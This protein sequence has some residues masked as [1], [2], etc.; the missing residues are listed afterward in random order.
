MAE[1]FREFFLEL[2]LL[3]KK[4]IPVCR[5]R[6]SKSY[7]LNFTSRPAR[8][9][10]NKLYQKLGFKRKETNVYTMKFT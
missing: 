2:A 10:A 1:E 9:A 6:I 8:V 3:N 7:D 5:N 4:F